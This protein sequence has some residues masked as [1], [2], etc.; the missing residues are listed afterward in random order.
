MEST[1]CPGR[2]VLR[3]QPWKVGAAPGGRADVIH[4]QELDGGV[5]DSL[6]TPR[7]AATEQRGQSDQI[8]PPPVTDGQLLPICPGEKDT[9]DAGADERDP[10][11]RARAKDEIAGRDVCRLDDTLEHFLPDSAPTVL[12]V[13]DQSSMRVPVYG[14][15]G[16]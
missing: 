11:W 12:D 4:C 16:L 5:N 3:D 2:D 6:G 7:A 10:W 8:A 1:G 9:D 15:T 14:A 13:L